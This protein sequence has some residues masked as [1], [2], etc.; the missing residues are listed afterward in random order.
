MVNDEE[1]ISR[2]HGTPRFSYLRRSA[3]RRGLTWNDKT[4]RR[5]HLQDDS[6]AATRTGLLLSDDCP[7]TT[8]IVLFEGD[9]A[10]SPRRRLICRGSLLRQLDDSLSTLLNSDAAAPEAGTLVATG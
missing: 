6:G 7:F 3:R 10:S 8:I 4:R 2:N 9:D 5:L 1:T